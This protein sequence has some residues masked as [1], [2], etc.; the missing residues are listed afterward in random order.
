MYYNMCICMYI[1][2]YTHTLY[3]ITTHS[4][5][6]IR[7]GRAEVLTI[8]TNDL[9]SNRNVFTTTQHVKHHELKV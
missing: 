5:L 2:I 3:V 4:R 6:R 8:K 1:Y 9:I 7:I